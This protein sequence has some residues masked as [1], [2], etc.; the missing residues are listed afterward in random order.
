[1]EIFS[2]RKYLNYIMLMH[3]ALFTALGAFTF[4]MPWSKHMDYGQLAAVLKLQV[5]VLRDDQSHSNIHLPY[6]T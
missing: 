4:K 5:W 1:M 6:I 3:E 2:G